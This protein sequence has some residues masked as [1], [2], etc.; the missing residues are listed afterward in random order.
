MADLESVPGAI[1]AYCQLLLY[2]LNIAGGKL[3]NTLKG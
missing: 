1:E 3:V 2:R